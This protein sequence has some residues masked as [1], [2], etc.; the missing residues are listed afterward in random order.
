[1]HVCPV[2]VRKHGYMSVQCQ[3]RSEAQKSSLPH[4]QTW[5]CG[6][7]ELP[8]MGTGNQTWILCKTIMC[9]QSPG[10]L[11]CPSAKNLNVKGYISKME[12]SCIPKLIREVLG[13]TMFSHREVNHQREPAMEEV[14]SGS[15]PVSQWQAWGKAVPV[16]EETPIV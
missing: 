3:Q 15:W 1:M 11:P 10:H 8:D 14:K 16:S 12:I 2:P 5:S 7:C 9:F 4:F 6:W 13:Q